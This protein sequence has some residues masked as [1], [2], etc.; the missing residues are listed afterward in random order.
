MYT[1]CKCMERDRWRRRK[2]EERDRREESREVERRGRE[3]G[4]KKERGKG[5]GREKE[6]KKR[7]RASLTDGGPPT[8]AAI[9]TNEGAFG[10]K[11]L[12]CARFFEV[13]D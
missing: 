12:D 2:E 6:R 1:I 11:L 4:R 8:V 10:L 5:G 3:G 9:G 13:M 7:G